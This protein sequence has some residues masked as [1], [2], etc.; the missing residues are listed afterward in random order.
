M[1]ATVRN[2]HHLPHNARG[3]S[4]F[5]REELRPGL[6]H[7]VLVGGPEDTGCARSIPAPGGW[8]DPLAPTGLRLQQGHSAAGCLHTTGP[9]HVSMGGSGKQDRV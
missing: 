5:I 1:H 2:A 6:R 9:A 4:C 7:T 3:F 8:R